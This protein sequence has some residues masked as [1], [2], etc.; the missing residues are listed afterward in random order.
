V[1]GD[2]LG[3]PNVGGL[4]DT[5]LEEMDADKH[6]QAGAASPDAESIE[7]SSE[8]M[9][10]SMEEGSDEEEEDEHTATPSPG[11][12]RAQE[13]VPPPAPLPFRVCHSLITSTD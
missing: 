1:Q 11:D 3:D 8:D 12:T 9:D 5:L 4:S 6:A 13:G 7:G 2:F 10:E